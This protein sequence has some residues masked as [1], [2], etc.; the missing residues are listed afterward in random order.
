MPSLQQVATVPEGPVHRLTLGA[1]PGVELDLVDLGATVAGLRVTGG[2]G[3]RRQ[4]AVTYA[5]PTDTLTATEYLGGTI[6]RVA[7][8]VAGA[9]FELDG[10]EVQ[11]AANEGAH[12]LH[13]GP[14]G[15]DKRLWRVEEHDDH[16]AVL[17]LT[18]DDGDQGFPGT[19]EVRLEVEV[20]DDTLDLV[21]SATTDAPTPVALTSH[22]YLCLTGADETTAGIRDHD[23]QLAANRV[24]HVD[25]ELIPVAGPA[26]PLDG[27]PYDLRTSRHLADV[28][29]ETGGGLDHDYVLTG[30]GM[31]E[32][33]WLTAPLARSRAVL[34]TDQ[35]DLQVFT[36]QGL[37]S[38][39]PYA[40]IALEPQ[41]P[42]D[43]VNRAGADGFPDITL[44]PGETYTC[45]ISWR[46]EALAGSPA[47]SR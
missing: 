4:V 24:H 23:L 35:P 14:V 37:S 29:A 40:G 47:E 3:V 44:R 36:G 17:S 22:L 43:A 33:A 18:S 25:D 27:S 10:D 31:R 5:D 20:G 46:F 26:R 30:S 34:S 12:L 9:R 1:A 15:F 39:R 8:R 6:G 13:G 2:D 32:V 41:T 7:N 45:R 38:H 21:L 42:P 11:V 16:R 28:V 19:L